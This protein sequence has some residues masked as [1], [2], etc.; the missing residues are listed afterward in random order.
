MQSKPK[1]N[2]IITSVLAT[3]GNNITFLVRGHTDAPLVLDLTKV[4]ADNMRR[5]ALHGFNQRIPDGAA[6]GA[7]DKDG[8]IVPAAERDALKHSRMAA[9]VAHYNSGTAEWSR[10]VEGG[11][12]DTGGIELRAIAA[13]QGTDVPTMRERV[14]VQ[15][16]KLGIGEKEY[17]NG[18]VNGSKA[19]QAKIAEMRAAVAPAFDADEALKAL[20][21]GA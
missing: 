4:S 16:E 7:A 5:A 1:A 10:K 17:L 19:V 12:R 21:G 11:T 2:S 15:A 20:K 6:I 18:I 8:N 13:I 14:K 3:D 9:L